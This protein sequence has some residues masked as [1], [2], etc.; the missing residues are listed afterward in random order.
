M[1]KNESRECGTKQT[2]LWGCKSKKDVRL[3]GN[4][5]LNKTATVDTVTLGLQCLFMVVGITFILYLIINSVSLKMI[6]IYSKKEAD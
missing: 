4:P 5:L 2:A 1:G 3:H 6:S